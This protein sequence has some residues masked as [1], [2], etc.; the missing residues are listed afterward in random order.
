MAVMM[1]T[2]HFRLKVTLKMK[3]RNNTDY[4]LDYKDQLLAAVKTMVDKGRCD[5]IL[6]TAVIETLRED[7]I[8]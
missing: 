5:D 6:M 7:A 2:S 4:S 8:D 1:M 3:V